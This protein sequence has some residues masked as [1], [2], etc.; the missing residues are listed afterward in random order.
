[1]EVAS[2][3]SLAATIDTSPYIEAGRWEE[4]VQLELQICAQPE[5]VGVGEHLLF[6]ARKG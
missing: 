4:L 3:P 2:T 5:V 1:M 6:V